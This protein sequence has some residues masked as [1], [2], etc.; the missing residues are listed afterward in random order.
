MREFIVQLFLFF[1]H[2]MMKFYFF[3]HR[4]TS[5]VK[6]FN[7]YLQFIDEMYVSGVFQTFFY[8]EVIYCQKR[9]HLHIYIQACIFI[10]VGLSLSKKM[11]V[12][13][14]T[15]N[16]FIMMKNAFYFILTSFFILKIFKFLSRLFGHVGKTA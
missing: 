11:C 2:K 6:M 1:S 13:C 15:E 14:L 12:N 7:K 9:P 5:Y 3:S 4:L 8:S 10:E 16:P